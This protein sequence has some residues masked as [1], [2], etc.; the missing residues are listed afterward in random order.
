MPTATPIGI[1]ALERAIAVHG[2][3]SLAAEIGVS[4]Q[5]IQGWRKEGRKFATP[6]EYC[7]SVARAT[8]VPVE[9]LRPDVFG[10]RLRNTPTTERVA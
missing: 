8:G 7:H 2:L 9:E 10:D 3:S 1:D 6:A 5:L 4:Y